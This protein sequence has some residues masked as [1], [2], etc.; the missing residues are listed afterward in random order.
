MRYQP[1]TDND[2]V[3]PATFRNVAPWDSPYA[4]N[5]HRRGVEVPTAE[6]QEAEGTLN[7]RVDPW[8]IEALMKYYNG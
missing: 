6:Q 5:G 1:D 8:V 3:I 4:R 7:G 2:R